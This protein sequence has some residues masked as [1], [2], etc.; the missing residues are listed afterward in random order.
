MYHSTYINTFARTFVSITLL[1]VLA[2]SPVKLERT[3]FAANGKI[4]DFLPC[5]VEAPISHCCSNGDLC[6]DNG[7]CLDF[8]WDRFYEVQGCTDPDWAAPCLNQ[9]RNQEGGEERTIVWACD[10]P[11]NKHTNYCGGIVGVDC[12]NDTDNYFTLPNFNVIY[13][14]LKPQNRLETV[15]PGEEE[16]QSSTP[17]RSR[18]I[19]LSNGIALGVGIPACLGIV[20]A[21]FQ[22][23]FPNAR[24]FRKKNTDHDQ[25]H[26]LQQVLSSRAGDGQPSSQNGRDQQLHESYTDDPLPSS[27]SD[28]IG[29]LLES[30]DGWRDSCLTSHDPN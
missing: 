3:C 13:S 20:V 4:I 15:V 23:Q 11:D 22:W 10:V 14:P 16:R 6:L 1:E 8:G 9:F 19:G 26:N 28:S 21:L 17:S 29:D 7:L 25:D 5:N 18:G 2:A 27:Y 24:L 30:E 12:C